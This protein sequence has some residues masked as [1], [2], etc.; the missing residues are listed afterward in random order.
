[1]TGQILPALVG[2]E[3]KHPGVATAATV[4]FGECPE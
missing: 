1:M 3:R 4:L 2:R